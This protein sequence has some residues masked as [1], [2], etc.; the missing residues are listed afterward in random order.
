M[1][2][3]RILVVLILGL[4]IWTWGIGCSTTPKATVTATENDVKFTENIEAT[5]TADQAFI[6]D[7][8][9]IKLADIPAQL[10][11]KNAS[12]YITLVVMPES[13]MTRE[14][15]VDLIKTLVQNDYFVSIGA[16]S[17]Y[18]DVPIPSRSNPPG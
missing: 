4:G 7:G 1:K 13:K 6:M 3:M 12:K 5:V 15:M 8:K 16:T 10:V 2:L 9:K 14:T 18:A 17:K 11:K